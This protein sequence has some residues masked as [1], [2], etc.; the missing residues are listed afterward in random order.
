MGTPKLKLTAIEGFNDDDESI[1]KPELNL[2]RWGGLFVPSQARGRH[3]VVRTLTRETKL[4]NGNIIIDS[5]VIDYCSLGTLTT[6]DQRVLYALLH[7]WYEKGC[8]LNRCHFS[9]Y[10]LMQILKMNMAN[11]GSHDVESVL[12]SLRRL[13]GV[14][15][16]FKQCFYDAETKDVYKDEEPINIL[17]EIRTRQRQN[18]SDDNNNIYVE[19]YFF[20]H[21]RILKNLVKKHTRPVRLDVILSLRSDI[22]QMIY[23]LVDR[24][25]TGKPSYN[26][27]S[28]HLFKE[29]G[30]LGKDYHKPSVRK[31]LIEKPMLE[32]I[33]KPLS[34]GGIIAKAELTETKNGSDYKVIFY[35]KERP[36]KIQPVKIETT[37]YGSS[38][39]IDR[40]RREEPQ[41][42]QV[43]ESQAWM[44]S[45][46]RAIGIMNAKARELVERYP[47]EC[48]K[49]L[50][51]FPFRDLSKVKSK[52]AWMV[53][54][55]T[56]GY[57]IAE[58]VEE[59][60]REATQRRNKEAEKQAQANCQY[61]EHSPGWHMIYT[62]QHPNGAAKRCTHDAE[63]E[64]QYKLR[65]NV[66]ED[67]E[68]REEA[69]EMEIETVGA[70]L[71]P[72]CGFCHPI[73]PGYHRISTE[74]S[75]G[76]EMR[77][78]THNPLIEKQFRT[79]KTW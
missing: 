40:Q 38:Q 19:G 67:E 37:E 9:A 51:S 7:L 36:Q 61:C 57:A 32:L 49:Q 58:G 41:A 74:G 47:Y 3:N 53:T 62:E 46:L 50:E 21:P 75:P 66:S 44:I 45:E 18:N 76:W 77:E 2:E 30:L 14:L 69:E 20:F 1:V 39:L 16:T 25:I 27:T 73:A 34:S 31:R 26:I 24:Q 71:L 42:P 68:G 4:A 6:K 70:A 28:E 35:R 56:Q 43:N 5:V 54:A 33:G 29:L 22:A 8:P 78:C 60:Q 65:R 17:S 59:K 55:I 13:R 15:L 52:A 79:I 64:G 63:V 12:D 10:R 23:N 48:E 72:D 11:Y